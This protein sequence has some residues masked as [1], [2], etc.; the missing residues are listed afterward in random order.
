[1]PGAKNLVGLLAHAC[2]QRLPLRSDRRIG[3]QPGE[4][5]RGSQQLFG[6]PIRSLGGGSMGRWNAA[7]ARLRL[8]SGVRWS[9]TR[10]S[11]LAGPSQYSIDH[12]V[13]GVDFRIW[14]V[15]H[16]TELRIEFPQQLR[17]GR[18]G[19]TGGWKTQLEF[20][21]FRREQI[22]GDLRGLLAR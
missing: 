5:P 8:R 10:P 11:R 18:R 16:P 22:V 1:V 21:L 17:I 3:R 13:S 12:R 2:D 9:G 20:G 4:Q 7:G 14:I 6:G 19:G 15:P